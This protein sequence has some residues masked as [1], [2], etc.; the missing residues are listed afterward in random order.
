M[1]SRISLANGLSSGNSLCLSTIAFISQWW[2]PS[3]QYW[4]L[5]FM[6]ISRVPVFHKYLHAGVEAGYFYLAGTPRT[7]KKL[8]SILRWEKKCR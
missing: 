3:W 4:V 6:F 7:N 8:S 5:N 1:L 2:V